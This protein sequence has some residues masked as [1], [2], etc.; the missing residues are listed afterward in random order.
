[1]KTT[2][3]FGYVLALGTGLAAMQA[4]AFSLGSYEL[5]NSMLASDIQS[6]DGWADNGT[7]FYFAS[8]SQWQRLDSDSNQLAPAAVP[9]ELTDPDLEGV[10]TF[11][12]AVPGRSLKLRLGFSN[13]SLVNGDGADLAFFFLWDQSANDASV[14]L[15]GTSQ[16]LNLDLLRDAEGDPQV[17]NYA[18]WDGRAEENVTLMVAE[19][20][21]SDFGLAPGAVW[22]GGVGIRLTAGSGNNSMALSMAAALNTQ[23]EVSA[24]PL[25]A[26]LPLM[27]GGLSLLGLAVRRRG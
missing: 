24:V 26:A 9:S 7:D 19:A 4:G 27:L 8:G 17:A 25:P 11:L 2:N 12:A 13:T 6:G 3:L 20:D 15:N 10:R 1:M 14:H 16:A 23:A 18:I 22:N 21:L 5:D